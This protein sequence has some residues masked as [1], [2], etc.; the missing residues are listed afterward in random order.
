MPSVPATS[1]RRS[2]PPRN[3]HETSNWPIAPDS[4]RIS[5]IALSSASIGCTSVSAQHITSTRPVV[6]ADEV[7][8]DLDAVAAEV[9]DRPA[10]RLLRVPEPRAVRAGVRLARARPRHLAD[11]AAP[12]PC[13]APSASSACRRGPRGS[14]AK[15]PARSTVSRIRFASAPVRASGFVQSTALP[16]A[17][18]E[19]DRLLVQVV[20]QADDHRV[21]LRVRDRLPR[22]RSSTR[23]R[24]RP[25]RTR[26][27]A[28]RSASRRRARGRGCAGRAASACRRA[29]SGRCPSIVALWPLTSVA[30]LLE[31]RRRWARD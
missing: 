26:A 12:A 1:S 14:R 21:G 27:P 5:A 6:L 18:R 22:G 25:R 31:N 24:P 10:A 8:D 30:R 3:V 2:I 29:R 20:R 11:R 16:C 4:K 9:D 23:A 17:A 15:T 7:A 28:P 19:R 13:R